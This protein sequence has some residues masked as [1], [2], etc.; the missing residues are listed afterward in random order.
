MNLPLE[1]VDG[2]E[3]PRDP[4]GLKFR[5]KSETKKSQDKLKIPGY[6]CQCDFC[7]GGECNPVDLRNKDIFNRGIYDDLSWGPDPRS[8]CAT[9]TMNL[10]MRRA[11]EKGL[12][13]NPGMKE[14]VDM[15]KQI[16]ASQDQTQEGCNQ[17]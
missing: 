4:Q 5:K 14:A 8:L 16:S 6:P 13:S 17:Q 15:V 7:R 2:Y 11:W 10:N 3:N 1:L 9:G 12:E